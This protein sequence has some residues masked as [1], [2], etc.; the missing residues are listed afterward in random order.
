MAGQ[1]EFSGTGIGETIAWYT[2]GSPAHRMGP[3]DAV[4]P[5]GV[6]RPEHLQRACEVTMYNPP[7]S[8]IPR[9]IRISRFAI[10]PEL[11][12]RRGSRRG[13]GRRRV[14]ALS[15]A[16]GRRLRSPEGRSPVRIPRA[17]LGP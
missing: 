6:V 10:M 16:Q 9:Q 7:V 5:M 3:I 4:A 8:Q 1:L 13:Q 15:T 12:P 14:L 11:N 17:P 2:P